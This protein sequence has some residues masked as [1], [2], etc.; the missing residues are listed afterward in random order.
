MAGDKSSKDFLDHGSDSESDAV[1][2]GSES[3]SRIK[4]TTVKRG[5]KRQRVSDFVGHSSDDDSDNGGVSSDEDEKIQ[6]GK[7]TKKASTKKTSAP[8]KKDD[9][10]DEKED[11]KDITDATK[12]KPLTP[13]QLAEVKRKTKKTGVIYLS[14]IPPFMK[15]PKVRHLLSVFGEIGRI[16]LVPEDHKAHKARVKQGG[17]KKKKFVEGWVEFLDKKCAKLCVETLNA[18]IVGGKKGNYYHDDVWNM[19]YLQGFKW[20]DLQAQIAYENASRQAKMRAEIAQATRENK[21]FLKNVERAKMVENM[22]AKKRKRQADAE[23]EKAEG[24]APKKEKTDVRRTFR[25]NEIAAGNSATT[26]VEKKKE[27]SETVGKVLKK[28]F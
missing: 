16:F 4:S 12:L 14:S 3:D 11:E 19:K 15:P 26:P 18:Q 21:T 10:D 1:H 24:S 2:S 8:T 5:A 28:I 22:E 20:G 7:A 17:N 9:S 13:A 23:G 27:R 25:Q 6:K